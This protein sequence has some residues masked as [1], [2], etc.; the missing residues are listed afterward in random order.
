MPLSRWLR[1]TPDA[2][3]KIWMLV[4]FLP[5]VLEPLHLSMSAISWSGWPSYAKGA[6]FSALDAVALALYFSLPGAPPPLPF[7]LSMALYFLA[8]LLSLF[9]AVEPEVVLF[10]AWQLARIFFVYAVVVRACTDPRVVPAILKGMAAGLILEAGITIWQRFGLGLLQTS[11]NFSHQNLLGMVSLFV[12][13]PFF[14]LLLTSGKGWLPLLV[15]LASCV[16]EVLTVSRGIIGIAGFGYATVF[17]LCTMRR[18]TSRKLLVLLIA[19]ATAAA[20]SPFVLSSIGHRNATNS[21]EDSDAS[22]T[23]LNTEAETLISDYPLGVGANQYVLVARDRGYRR[24]GADWAAPVHN[25]YLLVTAETGYFGLITFIV[26]LLGAPTMALRCGW[27]HLGDL[28]GHLLIGFGVALLAVYVQSYFEWVFLDIIPQYILAL[29]MGMVA[30]LARQ[31]G[32]W[33]R[34]YPKGARLEIRAVH[35]ASPINLDQSKRG[36]QIATLSRFLGREAGLGI[37]G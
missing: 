35:G 28:R 16:I 3:P 31:M 7:R 5:F 24:P 4:G 32:Y 20:L 2:A 12:T 29:E 19:F 14:A 37:R 26:F 23:S 22:R 17:L 25:V 27:R 9:Q 1:R 30:G 34:S 13:F 15:V 36:S 6:E 11:G 33:G 18:L 21:V 10:Y 8:V